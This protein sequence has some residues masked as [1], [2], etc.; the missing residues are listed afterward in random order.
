MGIPQIVLF[1][2]SKVTGHDIHDGHV[3]WQLVCPDRCNV[4]LPVQI[5]ED[6]IMFS[7]GYGIGTK[8]Y[9]VS[10]DAT[11]AWRTEQFWH[12]RRLKSKFAANLIVTGDFVYGLDDGVLVCLDASTGERTWKG[13]RYGHGQLLLVDNLLLVQCESGEIALLDVTPEEPRE[14]S[15]FRALDSR[16][17][18]APA[19]SGPYLLVRND[20]EAALFE[21]PLLQ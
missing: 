5:G 8:L 18:N 10:R 13:D 17:W 9:Q 2:A 16:V 20:V 15:R 1:H 14:L 12:S 7:A 19:L 4:T 21:L 6:R 11:G 3:L